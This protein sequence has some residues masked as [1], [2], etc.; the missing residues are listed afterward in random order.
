[1]LRLS[2]QGFYTWSIMFY[3]GIACGKR[4]SEV[5]ILLRNSTAGYKDR[6][7][8][9][10]HL[11]GLSQW[12]LS[13]PFPSFLILSYSLKNHFWASAWSQMLLFLRYTFLKG[14]GER[15]GT[16]TS[17]TPCLELKSLK[18]L[19]SGW[20]SRILTWVW[21]VMLFTFWGQLERSF[22]L[23]VRKCSCIIQTLIFIE[24]FSNLWKQVTYHNRFWGVVET[25]RNGEIVNVFAT[26]LNV[27][28]SC[29][30]LGSRHECWKM[31]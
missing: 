6:I 19:W 16:G 25:S 28:F 9:R 13:P 21:E 14:Q 3:Y 12:L 30:I 26:R 18:K 2:Q 15:E 20:C 29:L 31:P 27:F 8:P 7:W 1:M 17:S 11:P 5:F 10:F 23:Q 4:P 22:L 24:L